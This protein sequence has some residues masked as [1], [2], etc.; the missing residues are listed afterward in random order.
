MAQD[1]ERTESACLS[2]RRLL[3]ADA[4]FVSCLA[5]PDVK[6]RSSCLVCTPSFSY[7]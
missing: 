6:S 2:A 5:D 3:I 1:V 4:L 7:T